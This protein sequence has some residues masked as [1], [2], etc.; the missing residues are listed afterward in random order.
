MLSSTREKL[1]LEGKE[2]KRGEEWKEER[3]E[4]DRI[5]GT[6]HPSKGMSPRQEQDQEEFFQKKRLES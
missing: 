6:Y 3:E 2:R 4:R 1:S 5:R